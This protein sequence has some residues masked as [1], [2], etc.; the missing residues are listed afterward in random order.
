MQIKPRKVE[1]RGRKR[2]SLFFPVDLYQMTHGTQNQSS[3][4]FESFPSWIVTI[5]KTALESENAKRAYIALSCARDILDLVM[6]YAARVIL[7][8]FSPKPRVRPLLI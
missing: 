7:P 4:S 3:F 2:L 5:F 8:Q 6:E 1:K